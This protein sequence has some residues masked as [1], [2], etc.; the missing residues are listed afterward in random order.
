MCQWSTRSSPP[1]RWPPW[2]RQATAEPG[3]ICISWPDGTSSRIENRAVRL[4]C[5][6]ANC[7]DEFTGKPLLDPTTV[8]DDIEAIE[9][10]PL[11]HYAVSIVWSD[12]H[13][14]GIFSWNHLEKV[15]GN[16][17]GGCADCKKC[18]HES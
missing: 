14:S 8:P 1:R 7:V 16:C 6:C 11:G 5:K 15:A 2:T 4:S 9:I 17:G 10:A 13:A 18:I 3:Y 12:G